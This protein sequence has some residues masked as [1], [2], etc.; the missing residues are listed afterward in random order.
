MSYDSGHKNPE[1]MHDDFGEIIAY[2]KL[3][4]TQSLNN[5]KNKNIFQ[6][7]AKCFIYHRIRSILICLI[8]YRMG[9]QKCL[10]MSAKW[11]EYN[12]IVLLLAIMAMMTLG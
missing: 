1:C 7:F 9:T 3:N 12:N 4:T 10:Y 5:L 6:K 11:P 8:W 2:Y